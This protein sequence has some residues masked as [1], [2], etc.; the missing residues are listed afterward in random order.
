MFSA[1]W[2]IDLHAY[3]KIKMPTVQLAT[4]L[5]WNVKHAICFETTKEDG[6]EL[7]SKIWCQT[8]ARQFEKIYSD[9]RIRGQAKNEVKKYVD[10]TNFETKHS[11]MRHLG[12]T[13]SLTKY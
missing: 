13:V 4:F 10:G 9:T 7:I 3:T 11:V 12:S 5:N 8:C 1:V 2:A 6:K